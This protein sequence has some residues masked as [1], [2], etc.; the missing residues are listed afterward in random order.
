VEHGR[1]GVKLFPV[2][3]WER[4]DVATRSDELSGTFYRILFE[5]DQHLVLTGAKSPEG[6]FHHGGL[7]ALYLSSRADWAAKA[8][9]LGDSHCRHGADRKVVFLERRQ[10]PHLA[11]CRSGGP[12]PNGAAPAEKWGHIWHSGLG[13]GP[14]QLGEVDAN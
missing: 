10:G 5:A 14:Q 6:R 11:L 4:A 8:S 12:L 7:P 2:T 3:D 9:P 13:R 1:R